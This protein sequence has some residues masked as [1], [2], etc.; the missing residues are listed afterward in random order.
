MGNIR[1]HWPWKL[2]P[3]IWLTMMTR[4]D[5]FDTIH[6]SDNVGGKDVRQ[7]LDYNKNSNFKWSLSKDGICRFSMFKLVIL[8]QM[9]SAW[10]DVWASLENRDGE[11]RIKYSPHLRFN[12][13]SQVGLWVFFPSESDYTLL[14]PFNPEPE[15]NTQAVRRKQEGYSVY[16]LNCK[17]AP[18]QR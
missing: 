13:F 17:Q 1:E 4:V 9:R 11:C 7:A 6:N 2:H 8:N 14:A 15:I 12:R 16:L 3:I 5:S 18:C 10:L